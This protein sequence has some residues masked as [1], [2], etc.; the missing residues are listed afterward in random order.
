[1]EYDSH[2]SK[3]ARV[4]LAASKSARCVVGGIIIM[5]REQIGAIRSILHRAQNNIVAMHLKQKS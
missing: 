5:A 1:M 2:T 3:F 4:A